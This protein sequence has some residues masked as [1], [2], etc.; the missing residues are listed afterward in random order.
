MVV[1][2][3]HRYSSSVLNQA[4]TTRKG[5]GVHSNYISQLRIDKTKDNESKLDDAHWPTSYR[6]LV[7]PIPCKFDLFT[8][9]DLQDMVSFSYSLSR[10]RAGESNGDLIDK[11]TVRSDF[12]VLL[13]P[14]LL[15]KAV[16]VVIV[17]FFPMWSDHSSSYSFSETVLSKKSF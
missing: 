16:V 1:F 3:L 4:A 15:L 14:F 17:V 11:E 8:R 9:L 6:D 12:R 5:R 2:V 7:N 10:I 13:T